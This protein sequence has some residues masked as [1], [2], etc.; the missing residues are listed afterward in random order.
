M[1][2]N[3]KFVKNVILPKKISIV[4]YQGCCKEKEEKIETALT[5]MLNLVKHITSMHRI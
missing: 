2:I 5:I 3:H 4:N 1:Y